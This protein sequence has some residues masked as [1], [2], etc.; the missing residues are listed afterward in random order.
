MQEE[1]SLCDDAKLILENSRQKFEY[2]E[3][4]I[5]AKGN[6]EW[7]YKYRYDIPVFHLNGKFLM[8]HRINET[9]LHAALKKCEDT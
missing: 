1:C 4:D 6:E 7:F 5:T 8:Q 2:E 3:V 9:L